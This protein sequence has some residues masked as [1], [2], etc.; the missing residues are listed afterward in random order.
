MDNSSGHI[1]RNHLLLK[2]FCNLMNLISSE[3]GRFVGES[4]SVNVDKMSLAGR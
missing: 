4:R 2:Y 3:T 1:C